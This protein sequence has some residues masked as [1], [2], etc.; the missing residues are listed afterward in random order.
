[1]EFGLTFPSYWEWNVIIPTVTHSIIFQRGSYTMLYQQPLYGYWMI[2]PAEKLHLATPRRREASASLAQRGSRGPG[3]RCCEGSS[4]SLATHHAIHGDLPW[5]LVSDG[6]SVPPVD[7]MD[8]WETW[9]N[10]E[11]QKLVGGFKHLDY[12]MGC[13]PSH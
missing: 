12:Y 3:R 13:H 1:M 11:Q 5:K 8:G 2:L 10:D 6:I 4:E 9:E 7:G